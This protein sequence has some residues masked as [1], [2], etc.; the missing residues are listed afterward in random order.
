ML[1]HVGY[2]W[3]KF[4]NGQGRGMEGAFEADN[5]QL[6]ILLIINGR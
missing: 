2:F 1:Q 6:L 5:V 4:E 3:L